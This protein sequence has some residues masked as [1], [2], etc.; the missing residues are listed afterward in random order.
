LWEH[1]GGHPLY[2]QSLLADPALARMAAAGMPLPVPTTLSAT[3]TAALDRLPATA[4][5]LVE[6]LAVLDT[7]VPLV[8]AGQLAGTPDP[9]AA[10]HP[11]LDAGLVGWEPGEPS[12][13]VRIGHA[14]QRDAVYQAIPPE[15][16]RALH[17]TAA[18]LVDADSAWA[19]RVAACDRA[20]P[21][22]ADALHAEADR[23]TTTGRPAAR[24]D[25]AAVGRRPVPHPRP[26]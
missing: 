17:T 15:R 22:L 23:Q 26:A 3:V 7:R 19:H 10:L 24:R 1:T 11:L 14:L 8:L 6:A 9:A 20:D 12:A 21:D 2:L 13:P 18:T 4:R 25:A 16:R 5:G